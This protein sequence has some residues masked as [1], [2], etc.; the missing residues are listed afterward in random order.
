MARRKQ[1][2][3]IQHQ[4]SDLVLSDCSPPSPNGAVGKDQP[5]RLSGAGGGN[6]VRHRGNGTVLKSGKT[7]TDPGKEKQA[8]GLIELVIC[9][10]G[11]YVSFLTWAFLQERIT[12]TSYP[13]PATE[14]TRER[15][16]YSIF[17]NT[18]QS[19]FAFLTGSLYLHLTTPNARLIPSRELILPLLLVA[20]TSSLASPFGY[21]SLKHIDYITFILAKACKL[22]PV[23]ALHLTVFR[24]RYP[25]YKYAVVAAVTAGVA[26]F[27]LHHPSAKK[28]GQSGNGGNNSLWGLFLLA[29]NL[30]FDGLTNS[31]Q[32]YIFQ[33]F[34][35]YSGPQMMCVQNILNTLLTVSY[36]A[37]S[38][39]LAA[40]GI[41]SWLGVSNNG[42]NEFKD[43]LAFIG[44]HP[45]VGWDVLGFAACGAVGQVFIFYTLSHFSSLLL[46]TVT[47]T[48]KMLTM[49]LSVI[50][51]GHRLTP[52]QW[53][54]V[55]LV[56]GGVGAEGVG[57]RREKAEKERK[58][59][60]ER[61]GKKAA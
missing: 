20:I 1:A 23:M 40:T 13:S 36:L 44:R 53:L 5:V 12:T 34:Q 17:L 25:L 37:M 46:V 58:K 9:V 15:F 38:P 61:E 39:Y 3:P 28:K 31:T 6:S 60:A 33:T 41:G 4:N 54:G 7:T 57:Q 49:I 43:A 32:D 26:V 16:T 35:P 52:M 19:L 55:G 48:R 27:T 8:G 11:I 47:V 21:A 50:W 59:K 56:F 14:G 18:I 22:L 29:I 2:N 10:G 45:A 42:S 30:L 51:F 24:T